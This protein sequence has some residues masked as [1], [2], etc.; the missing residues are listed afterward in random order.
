MRIVRDR[1][2]VPHVYA[3]SRDDLFFAQG[4]VQAQDRLFQ[5]ELWRR[6][7]EGRLAQVM[8]AN[9]IERDAMTRRLQYQGE[10]DAEWASYGPDTRPIAEAFVRGINAWT[11]RARERRPELFAVAG[12]TPEFWASTDLL[13]RTDAFDRDATIDAAARH[14]VPEV[15]VDAVRRAAAPP[16]FTGLANPPKSAAA[17]PVESAA[18]DASAIAMDHPSRYYLIHLH[19]PQW[20]AIGAAIPW[21]PGIVVGHDGAAVFDR[22]EQRIAAT[23]KVTALNPSAGRIVKDPIEVKGRTEPFAAETQI[24]DDG[25]VIATDKAAGKAYVLT[26]PGHQRGTAP[27]FG[28]WRNDGLR[29]GRAAF[30]TTAVIFQHPLAITPAARARFNIGPLTPPAGGQPLFRVEPEMNAWDATRAMNAPGQSEDPASAHFSDLAKLWADG[31]ALTLPFSDAAVTAN[32]E[33][34]LT[35]VP[36]RRR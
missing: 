8:G 28:R 21:R 5:M 25:V 30:A 26:W 23:L 13:T 14:G 31:R 11:T 19:S 6:A 22:A 29:R 10:L 1:R 12:W 17:Q 7:S 4:F 34:T 32:A 36:D 35:L 18:P 27:A 2:G 9:F 33:A 3:E 20:H 16:F 24:V 15:V